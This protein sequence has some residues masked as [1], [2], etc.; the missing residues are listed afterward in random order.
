MASVPGYMYATDKNSI[1][2]NLYAQSKA[3]VLLGQNNIEIRQE[4][5]FPNDGN[6]KFF[7]RPSKTQKRM[8]KHYL[9][10]QL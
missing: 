8:E 2:I 7:I 3:N 5:V 4:T 9:K 6:V 1:Y 10:V